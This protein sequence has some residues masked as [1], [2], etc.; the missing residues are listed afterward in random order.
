MSSVTLSSLEAGSTW[1]LVGL[2]ANQVWINIQT[3]CTKSLVLQRLP[4]DCLCLIVANI[5]FSLEVLKRSCLNSH[6]VLGSVLGQD[7]WIPTMSM[8]PGTAILS[9][10]ESLSRVKNNS[11]AHWS[12]P[13]RIFYFWNVSLSFFVSVLT[14]E[15]LCCGVGQGK[16]CVHGDWEEE[17]CCHQ[18]QG[19]SRLLFLWHHPWWWNCQWC[20]TQGQM[21]TFQLQPMYHF[22]YVP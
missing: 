7:L 14:F 15:M 22:I 1:M 10:C 8:L 12:V 21:V 4:S 20:M 9:N 18:L 6:L 2:K 11:D 5:P 19:K 16:M 13:L 17:L 3:N